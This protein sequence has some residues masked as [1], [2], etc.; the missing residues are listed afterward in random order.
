M[1]AV[2]RDGRTE[3]RERYRGVSPEWQEVRH[4]FTLAG[5][6]EGGGGREGA[7]AALPATQ[8]CSNGL[9][10]CRAH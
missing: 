7:A 3:L 1:V 4:S 8:G 10:T 5:F 6:P 9:S 2:W